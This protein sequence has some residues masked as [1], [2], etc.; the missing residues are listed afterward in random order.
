MPD[1]L[2]WLPADRLPAPLAPDL[3]DWLYVDKGSL[4]RRLT[5]LAK[6]A[7]SVT[8]L[9]EGWQALR[10]DEC[11][12]LGVANGS[13]GWIREVY[14]RG[15]QEPWIFARSVAAR[16]ALEQS[17]LDLPH[18]GSRSLGELLFTDPAFS[19][20]TLQARQYPESWLPDEVRQPQLWARRSCFSQGDLRVLVAEVFLPALWRAARIET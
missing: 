14:L 20:G 1:S 12:A 10:D 4:T 8:P 9:A 3:H 2:D 5:Q 16:S 18:L 13:H 6:G 15:H 17:G 11:V 19:R 7:F